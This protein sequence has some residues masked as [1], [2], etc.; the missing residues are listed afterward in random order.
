MI[1]ELVHAHTEFNIMFFKLLLIKQE[2]MPTVT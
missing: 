2:C 1:A